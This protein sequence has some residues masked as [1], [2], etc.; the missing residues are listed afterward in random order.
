M[1]DGGAFPPIEHAGRADAIRDRFDL[2]GVDA[3]AVTDLTNVRWLTGFTGSNGTVAV[4]PDRMVLVTDPRYGSRSVDEL[5]A[6]GVSADVLVGATRAAQRDL[7]VGALSGVTRVGAE[8]ASLTYAGWNA[9]AGDLTLVEADGLVEDGR[10]S[11]DRGEIARIAAAC[12]YADAALAEVAITWYA[13]TVES[14]AWAVALGMLLGGAITHLGDRLFRDP[15]F[16]RGH[17]VDFINYNGY[18]IGNIADI[19]LVGG[20]IMIVV[21]SLMGIA[22]KPE[23]VVASGTDG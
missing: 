7:L 5:A 9:L 2:A 15:G 1:I 18:F 21:I 11:K 20:A 13:W 17:V 6:A 16:A 8:A 10:R 14:R 23:P 19:A 3:L 12:G 4:L 22:S